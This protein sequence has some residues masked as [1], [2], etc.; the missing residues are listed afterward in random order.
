MI[1]I[2]AFFAV[3]LLLLGEHLISNM[4]FSGFLKPL[5]DVYKER[6]FRYYDKVALGILFSSW[7]AAYKFY[8]RDKK[9]LYG[10]L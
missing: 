6:M 8:H 4:Q 7:V 3:G 9:R 1:V 10:M 2:G 5:E